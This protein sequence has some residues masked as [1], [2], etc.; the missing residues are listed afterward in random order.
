[1]SRWILALACSGFVLAPV[2]ADPKPL[3]EIDTFP[4]PKGWHPVRWLGF[5][6]D[7][8]TLAAQI[9]DESNREDVSSSYRLLAWDAATRKETLNHKQGAR[10]FAGG[11]MLANALTKVGTVLTAGKSPEEVR[12]ADGISVT[13][14][15][16]WGRPAGVWVNAD[17]SDSLWLADEGS[18]YSLVHGKMPPL[19]PDPKKGAARDEWRRTKLPSKWDD[20][21]F[22]AVA[23]N[24]DLTR[25]AV[26]SH[27]SRKLALYNIAVAN[28]LKFTEVASVPTAHKSG[29]DVLQFSADGRAL[30]TG[31]GDGNVCLWDVTKAG[32]DWKPH[33]TIGAG[34][35]TVIALAF[36]PDGKTLAAG[37]TGSKQ[38]QNLFVIDRNA[39]K[40]LASYAL[41]SAVTALAFS[42][43]G[44][45]LVTG[46][47]LGRVKAWDP[48]AL[49]NP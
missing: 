39:E 35:W 31:G 25:F 36:S 48:E 14:K 38:W 18:G 26:S 2:R 11:A 28:E 23:V 17:S 10:G 8:K 22:P 30:A 4:D 19:A 1:M 21:E 5:A 16:L 29:I 24:F 40:V 27:G 41:G 45:V 34:N 46:D 13:A 3:W 9:T 12:L 44:K 49:R 47:T 37:T 20:G 7:G 6:P 32:K 15:G 43:D 33:A 42:P